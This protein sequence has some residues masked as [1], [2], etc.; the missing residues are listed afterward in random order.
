MNSQQFTNRNIEI[1]KLKF[2]LKKR[3]IGIVEAL[4][5]YCSKYAGVCLFE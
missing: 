4:P 3:R 2:K 1:F 5:V